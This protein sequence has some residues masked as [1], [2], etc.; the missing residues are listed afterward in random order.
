MSLL[1]LT[2][3]N[4]TVKNGLNIKKIKLPQMIFFLEKTTKTIFMYLF[5]PVNLQVFK[6]LRVDSDLW[7]CAPSS[8]PKWPICSEKK[9]FS[10]NHYYHFYLP[11]ALFI[12][13]NLKKIL[14]VDPEP[15][16]CTIFGPKMTHFQ[17]WDIFQ[18]TCYIA[19][20]V[21]FMPIYMPKIKVRF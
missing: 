6:N 21:L 12:A 18:K 4:Q 17:K 9:Y 7:G 16:E 1:N 2:M 3:P 11:L 10:T 14:P 20:F 5:A 13:Q 19:V 15:W 8:G